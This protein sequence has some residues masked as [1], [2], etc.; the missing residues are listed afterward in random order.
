M[1]NEFADIFTTSIQEPEQ[2]T[3]D[4]PFD[5]EAWAADKKIERDK[6]YAMS[7]D[8]TAKV[9]A[10]PARFQQYLD[11]QSRFD[12]YTATNALLVM[13]QKPEAT[14]LGDLDHWK[15]KQ[16]YIRKSELQNPVFIMEPGNEYQRDDGSVGTSFNVKRVYDISQAERR[17]VQRGMNYSERSVIQALKQASPVNITVVDTLPDNRGAVYDLKA[18]GIQLRLEG[19]TAA[20]IIRSLSREVA[21]AELCKSGIPPQAAP[22]K[23]FSAS[24]ILCKKYGVDVSGYKFDQSGIILGDMEP[25]DVRRH[26]SDIR[27]VSTDIIGRMNKALEHARTEKAQEAR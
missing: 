14:Q 1:S 13:A 3:A 6:V 25:Q 4:Q 22:F 18:G 9:A 26:L 10:D 17:P 24:Y 2:P 15:G 27:N 20:D 21:M 12:R 11:T 5:K 7:D 19:L 16:V 23:A 8:V